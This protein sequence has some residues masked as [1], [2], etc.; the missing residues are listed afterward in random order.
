MSLYFNHF[1]FSKSKTV[2]IILLFGSNILFSQTK[3]QDKINTDIE[4]YYTKNVASKMDTN[5]IDFEIKNWSLRAYSVYKTSSFSIHNTTD[6]LNYTPKNP[7]SIGFGFAYYPILI[8][9]GF[10]IKPKKKDQT[11]R[12]DFQADLM[13]YKNYFGFVLQRYQGFNV[14]NSKNENFGFR[15]DIISTTLNLSYDYAFN[16]NRM[17]IG[18]VLSGS[19]I[20][21]KSAGSVLLGGFFMYFDMKADSS[22]IPTEL[23]D[24][25][26]TLYGLSSSLNIGGGINIGYSY[27]FVLPHNFFVFSGVNP[28]IGLLYKELNDDSNSYKSENLLV[29]KLNF[30]ISVGYNGPK[31]YIVL[32]AS[33]N[34]SF[35]HITSVY[36]SSLNSGKGK[37]IFGYKFIK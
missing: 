4:D 9:I 17:S 23:E 15:E 6:K 27:I 37:L 10:N 7:I 13:M 19:Q 30:K 26:G 32:T 2:I 14:D 20:Q 28:G 1:I 3:Y 25:F 22:I 5:Y 12:F 16:G 21:K 8:D 31:F 33:D 36:K 11:Q 29:Y 24:Q 35:T 18:S 34:I